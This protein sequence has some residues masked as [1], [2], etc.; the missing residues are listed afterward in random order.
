MVSLL[1]LI[2][3]NPLFNPLFFYSDTEPYRTV[4]QKKKHL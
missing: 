1:V 4:G 2:R 3:F